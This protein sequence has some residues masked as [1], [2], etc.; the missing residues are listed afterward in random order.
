VL[1]IS[2]QI[3]FSSSWLIQL[4]WTHQ[5]QISCHIQSPSGLPKSPIS[6]QQKLNMTA[7]H[8]HIRQY[9]LALDIYGTG[10]FWSATWCWAASKIPP[11]E[12]RCLYSFGFICIALLTGKS[13]PFE[14]TKSVQ[15]FKDSV[16]EGKRPRIPH[17][18][19][20]RLSGLIQ[21]FWD[22]NPH[23][24]P[25]F[26]HICNQLRYIEGLLLTG[27]YVRMFRQCCPVY[28]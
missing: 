22:G 20:S 23:G 18:C 26:T 7:P 4:V 12:N 24:R 21:R 16:R 19:L 15:S 14:K 10:G 11:H 1:V 3:T 8:I 9:P 2:S 28:V 13:S 25:N 27:N 6:A 17:D 5:L